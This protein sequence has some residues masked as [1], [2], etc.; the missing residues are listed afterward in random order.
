MQHSI[1]TRMDHTKPKF[2]SKN[3]Y[4]HKDN[5]NLYQDDDES[6]SFY[7]VKNNNSN[8]YRTL[9]IITTTDEIC[10]SLWG[11]PFTYANNHPRSFTPFSLV[12]WH[13]VC[14]FPP[15]PDASTFILAPLPT[16]FHNI[17]S[18]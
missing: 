1:V 18:S 12:T 17:F 11:R 10:S 16:P 2:W 13:T 7:Q 8:L 4:Q 9:I 14:N 5:N 15:L 3:L 6:N